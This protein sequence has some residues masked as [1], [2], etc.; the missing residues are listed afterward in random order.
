MESVLKRLR[1]NLKNEIA[2]HKKAVAL[3][4]VH[5]GYVNRILRAAEKVGGNSSVY[6]LYGGLHVSVRVHDLDSFKDKRL[7]RVL[8]AAISDNAKMSS[9]DDAAFGARDY[10]FVIG[11]EFGGI[12]ISI[13]AGLAAPDDAGKLCRRVLVDVKKREYVEKVYELVCE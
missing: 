4:A 3:V 2:A 5:G 12:A 10:K 7:A 1:V 11:P 6:A 9:K 8:K 13:H